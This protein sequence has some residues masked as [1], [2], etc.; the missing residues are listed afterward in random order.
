MKWAVGAYN[1]WRSFRSEIFHARYTTKVTHYNREIRPIDQSARDV[2]ELKADMCDFIVEIRKENGEQYP[3]NS[4]YDLVSGLSLYLEREH[5]FTNKLVSGAFRE[6]RNT[7]DNVMKERTAEGVVGRPE[8]EPILDEHESILWEKG[9]LGEDSPHKLRQTVFF[10]IGLRFGLRGLKE[11][12]D[13][14]R[15]P[16]SQINIVKIDG[17]DA[18]VY[19]EFQSKTRQGGISDR[20]KNPARVA[21]SFCTG[22]RPRC[23]VELYRKY[24]FLGPRGSYHWPKFYVQTDSSWQPGS[25]YWYTNRPVGKN[26]LG[27][28]ISR[29]WWKGGGY[30][31]TSEIILWGNQHVL[32]CSGRVWIPN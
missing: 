32:D 8:R 11:Q 17:K 21:Y 23:L 30:L 29:I 31:G 28:G 5:G 4:M 24:L 2:D 27:G 20:G 13:L 14:R 6:I 16:D 22:Y 7:L 1:R 15:Y 9:I 19:R 10:L 18:L 12:H 25:E 26:T 3:P